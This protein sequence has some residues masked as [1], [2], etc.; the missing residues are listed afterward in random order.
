VGILVPERS[1][2]L[3]IGGE[4]GG[5]SRRAQGVGWRFRRLEG[6]ANTLAS[7][8]KMQRNLA[9]GLL[10]DIVGMANSGTVKHG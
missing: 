7:N 1:N 8:T 4:L 9:D 6:L 3:T 10:L 5:R 2:P